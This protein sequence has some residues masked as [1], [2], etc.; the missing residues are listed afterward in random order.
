MRMTSRAVLIRTRVASEAGFTMIIALGVMFVTSLLLVAAFT[1]ANGDIHL[2]HTDTAQKQAYYAALA[3]VQEY[4]YELQVNPDYW[5]TCATP[6]STVI[7]EASEK[8]EIK[9]LPASSAPEGTLS[10]NPASPFSTMIESKGTLAN[11]FR[12]KST[13]I[14]GGASRSIVATFAVTGFLDFIYFTNYETLDP[15]IY[16]APPGCEEAYYSQWSPKGLKCQNIQFVSGDSV[17]GPMHT[18]DAAYVSGGTF[19]RS[20]HVP[21]DS[22]EINGGTYPTAGCTGGA[23]YYTS[24]GCYTKG[25]TLVP[26]ESDSSLEAYVEPSGTFE[27]VTHLTL[28]GTTNTIKAVYYKEGVKKEENIAWPANGLIYVESSGACTYNYSSSNADTSNEA[29][30]EKN[31]GTVYVSGTYSKSLTVAGENEV[32][33]NGSLYPT[34]VEGKLGSEP[35]GTATLG[36]I[37]TGF[38]RV[39]HP[40]SNGNNGSGSL[41][42]P[43]IYA[44]ILSTHHSFIVDNWSCGNELG[45]LN[46]YGAIAQDYRG[47]VGTTGGTGYLKDYKYDGRLATD[48]PPYFLAPL[49]AGWKV[50]RET[51]PNAG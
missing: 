14:A 49:K 40:C 27:G 12:I 46:V 8:Y 6:K 38:V 16:N 35:T 42:N 24:T 26:P 51:A 39:Y 22:V 37:A 15:G 29:T 13:G 41:E 50:I 23:T 9:L 43:W 3:G 33:V 48:E 47:A 20:G 11:T 32:I 19:G 2:S 4:E 34:S 21:A 30:E 25:Q 31:C 7:E 5:E 44:G 17:D 1:A 36:L 45:K 28:N 18:N 10:C